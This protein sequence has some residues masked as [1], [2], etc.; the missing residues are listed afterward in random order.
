MIYLQV[1]DCTIEQWFMILGQ[2]YPGKSDETY[3]G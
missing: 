3:A 1:E 2:L